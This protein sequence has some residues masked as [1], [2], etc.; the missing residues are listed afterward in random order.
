MSTP[1]PTPSAE[2]WKDP[3]RRPRRPFAW[4]KNILLLLLFYILTTGPLCRLAE[5][6]TISWDLVNRIYA[7]LNWAA[8]FAPLDIVL[9]WYIL[10][11]WKVKHNRFGAPGF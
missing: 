5:K 2:G 10:D 1:Q 6:K 7:P 9:D 11:V 3:Y 4:L 8:Q